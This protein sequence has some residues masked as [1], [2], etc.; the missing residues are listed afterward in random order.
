[1]SEQLIHSFRKTTPPFST[2]TMAA[3]SLLEGKLTLTFSPEL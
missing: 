3:A 2:V 1:V